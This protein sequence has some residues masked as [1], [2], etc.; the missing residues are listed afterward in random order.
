MHKDAFQTQNPRKKELT[1]EKEINEA[2]MVMVYAYLWY[3]PHLS[4]TN[5]DDDDDDD[6]VQLFFS[7]SRC[8]FQRP[9]SFKYIIFGSW[10]ICTIAWLLENIYHLLTGLA[11]SIIALYANL[12]NSATFPKCPEFE[13]KKREKWKGARWRENE[14]KKNQTSLNWPNAVA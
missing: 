11:G 10:A 7:C 14:N 4:T 5:G 8:H 12:F 9:G 6:D 1:T 13:T 3:W 2:C